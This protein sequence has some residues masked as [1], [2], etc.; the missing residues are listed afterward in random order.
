MIARWTCSSVGG[1]T[2]TMASLSHLNT[3]VHVLIL[4][5]CSVAVGGD[6]RKGLRWVLALLSGGV[7]YDAV[8]A[9]C[10]VSPLSWFRWPAEVGWGEQRR[11]TNFFFGNPTEAVQHFS[12]WYSRNGVDPMRTPFYFNP[13]FFF[14]L[15][16]P[17]TGFFSPR[18]LGKPISLYI[19]LHSVTSIACHE[20]K[21]PATKAWEIY[22]FRSAPSLTGWKRFLNLRS[23]IMRLIVESLD[24]VTFAVACAINRSTALSGATRCGCLRLCSDEMRSHRSSCGFKHSLT[25]ACGRILTTSWRNEAFSELEFLIG[26]ANLEDGQIRIPITY[27][28]GSQRATE[29]LPRG[30]FSLTRAKR[31][32]NKGESINCARMRE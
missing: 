16:S 30:K 4:F 27:L 6:S 29:K 26:P 18:F 25:N 5:Q 13:S 2:P 21:T 8:T 22:L 10:G 12:M 17:V 9:D 31:E 19:L 11:G 32:R 3:P 7:S 24:E 15:V 23:A 1:S 14:I 28:A 20:K